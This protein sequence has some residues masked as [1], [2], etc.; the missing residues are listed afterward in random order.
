M[1]KLICFIFGHKKIRFNCLERSDAQLYRDV[2]GQQILHLR[3]C[4]RCQAAFFEFG[5]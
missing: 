5:E 4:E 3:C 1:N 2:L